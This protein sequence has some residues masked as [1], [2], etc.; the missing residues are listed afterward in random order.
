MLD[1]SNHSERNAVINAFGNVNSGG[2]FDMMMVNIEVAKIVCVQWT[3]NEGSAV[4]HKDTASLT[5]HIYANLNSKRE[6]ST[7]TR[8]A[9]KKP[10][11]AS[12]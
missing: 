1:M 12:R 7:R 5:S 2:I 3:I 6:T 8:Q 4:S 10:E 9:S 11:P